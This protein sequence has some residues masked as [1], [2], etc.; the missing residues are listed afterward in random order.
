MAFCGILESVTYAFS[1]R[2]K[3]SARTFRVFCGRV[4][5]QPVQSG[6]HEG[7]RTPLK[8][9][10]RVHPKIPSKLFIPNVRFFIV[11]CILIRRKV[12]NGSRLE[13][14]AKHTASLT[15][16][17]AYPLTCRLAVSLADLPTCDSLPFSVSQK[18]DFKPGIEPF[19]SELTFLE[20]SE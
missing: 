10:K 1:T 20:C 11:R 4:G 2:P 8:P 14:G 19:F 13:F 6:T 5:K 3:V 16:R 9:V 17:L 18:C 15:C 7:R 12:H